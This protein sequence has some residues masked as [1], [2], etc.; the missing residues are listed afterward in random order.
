M[1]SFLTLLIDVVDFVLF[2][3]FLA[4]FVGFLCFVFLEDLLVVLA[5]LGFS[6]VELLVAKELVECEASG[7]GVELGELVEV[8]VLPERDFVFGLLDAA[9]DARE[10]SADGGVFGDFLEVVGVLVHDGVSAVHEG[11]DLDELLD[12]LVDEAEDRVVARLVRAELEVEA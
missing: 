4:F 8:L 7:R 10:P 12:P 3:V 2:V 9:V 1:W 6:R 11:G 5:Q